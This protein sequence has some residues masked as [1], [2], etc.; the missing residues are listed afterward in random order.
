MNLVGRINRF[1]TLITGS[2]STQSTEKKLYIGTVLIMLFTLF[3]IMLSNY[4]IGLDVW[5]NI[6]VAFFGVPSLALLYYF[7]RFRN[8]YPVGYLLLTIILFLTAS[9]FVNGGARGTI[10]MIYLVTSLAMVGISKPKYHYLIF[11]VFFSHLI[12]ML[13]LEEFFISDLIIPYPN[14]LAQFQDMIFSYGVAM[15]IVFW[16]LRFYKL[17]FIAENDELEKKTKQLERNISL[18]NMYFT[19]MVHD[20]K[21][22]F[23]NILGFSDLMNSPDNPLSHEE[24]E[25]FAKLTKLSALHSYE[26][27]E[28]ILE[29]SRIQQES[30]HL[31]TEKIDL[32]R[33]AAKILKKFTLNLKEKELVLY[34]KIPSETWVNSD[35]Y[36]IDTLLRNLIFNAVKFTPHGGT[37]TLSLQDF[38]ESEF[39]VSIKD[40][41]IGMDQSWVQNIFKLDF[42]SKRPG[43]DGELSNGIGLKICRELT[44]KQG[45]HIFVKSESGKG[46]TFTFTV[47]KHS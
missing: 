14:S 1:N 29:W 10:P 17:A 36:Y 26:L 16:I 38:S 32:R 20:L 3:P 46:S 27:L 28:D 42:N 31:K 9:W 15:L 11:L 18:K 35:N 7:A 34:N 8:F 43:T 21:G 47:P 33:S 37:I 5:V 25:R 44:E 4:V 13:L 22:S 39:A 41:G 6:L 23:N 24:Y 40:T 45:S 2:D 19:I 12:A 30:F